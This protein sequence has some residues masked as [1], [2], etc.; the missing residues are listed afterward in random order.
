M[1]T[2]DKDLLQDQV[3]SIA[4]TLTKGFDPEIEGVDGEFTAY[5]YLEDVLDVK[6][7]LNSD[8][9]LRGAELLVAFGGPNIWVN[10]DTGVVKG[11]W[12]GDSATATFE[13][14]V[15]LEDALEAWYG[16]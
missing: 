13:D 10:T 9:T 15:E 1:T 14:N 7:I 11:A 2:K 3:N 6:W 16:C 5:D 4:E 8:K 12:W